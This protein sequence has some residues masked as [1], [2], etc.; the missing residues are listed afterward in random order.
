MPLMK[1]I[2]LAFTF[3]HKIQRKKREGTFG[4]AILRWTPSLAAAIMKE[5]TMLFPSPI[6][7]TVSPCSDP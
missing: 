6:Q 1:Y 5:W 7:L 3:T 2:L 4:V